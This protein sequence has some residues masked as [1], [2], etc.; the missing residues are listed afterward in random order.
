MITTKTALYPKSLGLSTRISIYRGKGNQHGIPLGHL[1][2]FGKGGKD[3]ICD[4]LGE[5]FAEGRREFFI[6]PTFG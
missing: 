3:L 6:E 1:W 2:I 5:W 4:W